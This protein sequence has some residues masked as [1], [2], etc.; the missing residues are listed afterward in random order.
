MNIDLS[1]QASLLVTLIPRLDSP[2]N[3]SVL[4]TL[5][6]RATGRTPATPKFQAG[7]DGVGMR[8]NSWPTDASLRC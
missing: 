8:A 3:H 4:R 7:P 2:A 1:I 6:R 5:A